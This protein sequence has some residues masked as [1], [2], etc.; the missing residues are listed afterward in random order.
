MAGMKLGSGATIVAAGPDGPDCIIL[1]QTDKFAAKVTDADEISIKGRNTGGLRVTKFRDD[2]RIEFAYVGP[3]AGINLVL[4]TED[5]P[6]KPDPAPE[7]L[8]IEHTG[9]DLMSKPMTRKILAVGT[10]RW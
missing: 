4:G 8:T 2:K 1:T 10:G 9:R 7:P 6:S 5:A 3:E